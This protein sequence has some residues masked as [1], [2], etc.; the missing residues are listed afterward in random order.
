LAKA[1]RREAAQ[2]VAHWWGVGT[3]RVWKWRKALGDGATTKGTSRLPSPYCDEPW[4]A[5]AREKSVAKAGDPARREKPPRLTRRL[6]DND[7]AEQRAAPG[8][9]GSLAVARRRGPSAPATGSPGA[10]PAAQ[11]VGRRPGRRGRRPARSLTRTRG[12]TSCHRLDAG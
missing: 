11:P 9:P 6:C 10:R 1:V 4:F 5:A 8:R 3:D 12:A 2:A 7:G